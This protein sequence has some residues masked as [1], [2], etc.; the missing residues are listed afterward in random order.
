MFHALKVDVQG[1]TKVF[2]N[3]IIYRTYRGSGC[4]GQHRNS[5]ESDVEAKLDPKVASALGIP[6]LT[7]TA[8][9]RYQ[10]RNIA[11]AG[12]TL[13]LRIKEALRALLAPG[14]NQAGSERV[15]TY[16]EPDNRVTDKYGNE[17][18]WRQTVGKGDIGPLIQARM[19]SEV[20]NA[21]GV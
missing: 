7:A 21:P 1:E 6:P 17:M 5:T 18:A 4:G 14:R 15:R 10:H 16:H 13:A 20:D 3:A 12:K 2:P 11:E 9:G 19:K 8:T